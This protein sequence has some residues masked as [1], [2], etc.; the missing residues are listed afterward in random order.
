MGFG[1]AGIGLN[2]MHDANYDAYSDKKWVICGWSRV[3]SWEGTRQF[4][5]RSAPPPVPVTFT[6]VDG[7]DEDIDMHPFMRFSH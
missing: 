2:I 5:R 6:N 7:L 1:L 3:I 4:G